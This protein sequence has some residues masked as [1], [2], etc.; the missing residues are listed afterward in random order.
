MGG[1]CGFLPTVISST[2]IVAT[3]IWWVGGEWESS[4]DFC[5]QSFFLLTSWL[6]LLGV[7]DVHC[8][9]CHFVY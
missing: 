9:T 1:Q 2:D 3:A 5:L 8:A 4:V 6:Q 7:D